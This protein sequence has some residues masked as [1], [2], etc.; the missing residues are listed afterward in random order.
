MFDEPH[1]RRA[2]AAGV[3][4]VRPSDATADY[5]WGACDECGTPGTR[6]HHVPAGDYPRDWIWQHWAVCD[7]CRTRWEVGTNLFSVPEHIAETDPGYPA[8]CLAADEMT[9]RVVSGNIPAWVCE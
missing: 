1:P 7:N 9:Y 3:T 5:E 4:G 6:M 8:E 2:G